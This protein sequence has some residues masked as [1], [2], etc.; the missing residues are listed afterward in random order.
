MPQY[1]GACEASI[2]SLKVRTAS[3]AAGPR[4][5]VADLE[6]ARIGGNERLR[7]WGPGG[8]TP[9]EAW[10]RREAIS[11]GER[12]A[13]QARVERDRDEVRHE[14]GH[15]D[16]SDIGDANGALIERK[17]I[18][19]ALVAHGFLSIRRRRIPPV[20]SRLFAASVS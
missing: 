5:T 6:A 12:S 16:L 19:R 7:P 17:A 3:I 18:A 15:D 14:L 8:P 11:P 4:W 10:G 2:G 1:N 20:L 9:A 13:F